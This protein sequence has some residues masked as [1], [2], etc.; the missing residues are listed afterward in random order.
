MTGRNIAEQG[1]VRGFSTRAN[2]LAADIPR[3]GAVFERDLERE[4]RRE[5]ERNIAQ[6]VDVNVN[7]V[8][9]DLRADIDEGISTG[10]VGGRGSRY[11][12]PR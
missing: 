5:A 8:N 9:G 1:G 11:R 3:L 4:A 6:R 10:E 12:R 7:I 2:D